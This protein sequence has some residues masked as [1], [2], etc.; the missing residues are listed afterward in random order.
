MISN[1]LYL[2]AQAITS[3]PSRSLPAP[4]GQGSGPIFWDDVQCNGTEQRLRDC[5][6]LITPGGSIDCAHSEDV[7]VACQPLPVVPTTT[8]ELC[9][10]ILQ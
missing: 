3:N 4:F 10:Q 8:S 7:G 2:G 9:L 1:F 5:V 6:K